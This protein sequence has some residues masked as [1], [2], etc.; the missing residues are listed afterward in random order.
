[1]CVSKCECVRVW[2]GGLRQ[3]RDRTTV[4][5][6]RKRPENGEAHS[7]TFWCA[8]VHKLSCRQRYFLMLLQKYSEWP[9]RIRLWRGHI[10]TPCNR[11]MVQE[12]TSCP[13]GPHSWQCGVPG[14]ST[15]E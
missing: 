4:I 7:G 6:A 11:R 1:M 10:S 2:R 9:P 14:G 5:K 3:R 15:V 13:G 12:R 8:G